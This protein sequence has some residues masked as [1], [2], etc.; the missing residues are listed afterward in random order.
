M[1]TI[2]KVALVSSFCNDQEKIDV[3]NKNID[4]IREL[5]LDI[6]VLSPFYLPKEIV[7]KCDYFFVTKDN[8]VYEW[9]KKGWNFWRELSYKGK[10][11]K[12]SKTVSDYGW[13]G[14]HQVKQLSELALNLDYTHYYHLI[15]DLKITDSIRLQ[16]NQTP[17]DKVVFPSKRGDTIWKVGLHFMIFSKE[18]LRKFTS[19][20]TEESYNTIDKLDSAFDW[21]AK[22]VDLMPI[23]IGD[24]PVE[25]EIYIFENE[26]IYNYS[27]VNRVKFFI[28]K[29]D[30]TQ[31][32]I[33]LFFYDVEDTKVEIYVYEDNR[34]VPVGNGDIIDLNFNKFN[35]KKVVLAVDQQTYDITD[36]IKKVKHNTLDIL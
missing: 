29:N 5:G 4:N 22:I 13:A 19:F 33:K 34:H 17:P 1:E 28:E 24:F 15:Y 10:K 18:N 9:P 12:M 6:I 3:L 21:L 8:P 7:D 25:D 11:L 2:K 26:D 20:I 31:A 30:E 35:F 36:I 14:V 23:K 27:P 32:N 16:F